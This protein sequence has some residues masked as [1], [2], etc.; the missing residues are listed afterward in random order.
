MKSVYGESVNL[1]LFCLKYV[2]PF[3]RAPWSCVLREST[4]EKH[5]ASNDLRITVTPCPMLNVQGL[6]V[7]TSWISRN[8]WWLTVNPRCMSS[9]ISHSLLVLFVYFR[10]PSHPRNF[11]ILGLGS[12]FIGHQCCISATRPSHKCH[13]NRPIITS[14]SSGVS[15][16][17]FVSHFIH[18]SV[19]KMPLHHR[20]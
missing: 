4:K 14:L 19:W 13:S 11:Q 17:C 6:R 15:I 3:H 1:N 12:L 2:K 9:L 10:I 16:Q 8:S 7:I 5:Q 18:V 20:V